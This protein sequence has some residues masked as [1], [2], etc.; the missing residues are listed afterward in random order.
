MLPYGDVYFNVSK[1]SFGWSGQATNNSPSND[2]NFSIDIKDPA[3]I[4]TSYKE[5]DT[6]NAGTSYSVQVDKNGNSP[7]MQITN[8]GSDGNYRNAISYVGGLKAYLSKIGDTPNPDYVNATS[9][10]EWTATPQEV[11][12]YK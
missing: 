3:F 8:F 6:N 12:S 9:E 7:T 4:W 11:S 2:G 1:I 10:G 5:G